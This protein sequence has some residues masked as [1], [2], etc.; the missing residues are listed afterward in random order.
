MSQEAVDEAEDTDCKIA[1]TSDRGHGRI[2]E[3]KVFVT[4]NLDFL[5]SRKEWVSIKSMRE[6]TSTRICKGKESKEKRY[7]ISS[8]EWLPQEAALAIPS[9]FSIENHLHG[10]M[11]MI[12]CEDA[13]QANALDAAENLVMFRRTAMALIKQDIAG[14]LGEAKLRREAAWD[15]TCALLI[16][17]KLFRTKDKSF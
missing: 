14:T 9:H 1:I 12:F 10:C 4:N 17:G 8:K 5:D 6:V 13:H 11:D 3:R 15:D 7:Y 16:L 2:E